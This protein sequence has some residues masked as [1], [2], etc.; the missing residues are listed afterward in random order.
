MQDVAMTAERSEWLATR[1]AHSPVITHPV[2]SIAIA[3]RR[4]AVVP[5]LNVTRT[6]GFDDDGVAL[7]FARAEV[8]R[9]GRWRAA[10]RSDSNVASVAS[11][12][13]GNEAVD[14]FDTELWSE[15][16]VVAD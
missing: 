2:T 7:A 10:W 13:H 11:C 3:D 15:L 4:V 16:V 5:H 1:T 12:T 14:R 6:A 9:R 8:D